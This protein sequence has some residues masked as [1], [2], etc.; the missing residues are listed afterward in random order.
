[1]NDEEDLLKKKNEV[2]IVPMEDLMPMGNKIEPELDKPQEDQIP[3]PEVKTD[4]IID[5]KPSIPVD[6]SLIN[7]QLSNDTLINNNVMPVQEKEEKN[8]TILP[9]NLQV[10]PSSN[11]NTKSSNNIKTII[12]IVVLL[13]AIGGG[14][15]YILNSGPSRTLVCNHSG[16]FMEEEMKF[17][18][19][20]DKV[21]AITL[22]TVYD[23]SSLS[24][25]VKEKA[26][27]EDSCKDFK[28][29]YDEIYEFKNCRQSISG[30]K[31]TISVDLD[32]KNSKNVDS[33]EISKFRENLEKIGYTCNFK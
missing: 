22:Q 26:K 30:D 31:I 11:T 14:L 24:D 7:N 15:Y 20:N 2:D 10:E 17:E 33:N 25:D 27:N 8:Q 13:I 12:M 28:S 21:D 5:N 6:S 3:E 23:L 1:M 19:K 32:V 16:L 9:A 4:P 18:I 29:S